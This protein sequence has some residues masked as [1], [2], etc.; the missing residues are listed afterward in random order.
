MNAYRRIVPRLTFG[1]PSRL[2]PVIRSAIETV[3]KTQLS[4][5]NQ[6]YHVLLII[7]VRHTYSIE[8]QTKCLVK[9]TEMTPIRGNF[10]T[11]GKKPFVVLI[12]DKLN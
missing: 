7:T 3:K 4:Q 2:S 10:I 11:Q 6:Q 5:E 9:F 1:G 12:F 8:Q